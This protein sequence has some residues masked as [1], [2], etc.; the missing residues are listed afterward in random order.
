[1]KLRTTQVNRVFFYLDALDR[2]QE[3]HCAHS[4]QCHVL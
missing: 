4:I 2:G 3:R 1:M